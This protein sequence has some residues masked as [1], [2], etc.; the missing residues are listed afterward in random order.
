MS[1]VSHLNNRRTSIGS[2]LSNDA[3]I[4]FAI[5]NF[6]QSVFVNI[7]SS[8][9]PTI[10]IIDGA[11]TRSGGLAVR[12]PALYPEHLAPPAFALA[13]KCRF[14]YV[15]GEMARGIATTAM[16]CAAVKSGFCAFFGSA[17]LRVD[18]VEK[19]IDRIV[20]TLGPDEAAWGMNLI[21][22]PDR[23]DEER[24]SIDLFLRRGV[25]RVSASAFMKLSS[26]V[27]RYASCGLRRD[28]TGAVVRAN[29]V[30]AKISRPE[31]AAQFMAPPPQTI[32][33]ELVAA[34]QISAEEATLAALTP[35]AADITIEVRFRRPHRQQAAERAVPGHRASARRDRNPPSRLRRCPS[36]RGGRTGSPCRPR[37]GVRARRRLCGDR[38]DQPERRRV[39]SF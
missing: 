25:R 9:I 31:V 4:S 23:P 18:A 27:V 20:D 15:V 2:D 36:W 22:S 5:R 8:G 10:E 33:R 30:F 28:A 34:G 39:R 26:E 37:G 6:R 38:L 3:S 16:V 1:L 32:L 21:H 24:K 12:L 29:H 11:D 13:H 7:N 35:V 17:G 14:P 19:A